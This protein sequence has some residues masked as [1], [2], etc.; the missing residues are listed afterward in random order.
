MSDKW[1]EILA[2]RLRQELEVLDDLY[3]K[4]V[5]LAYRLYFLDWV[6]RVPV[7]RTNYEEVQS[8]MREYDWRELTR[9]RED[10]YDDTGITINSV[11]QECLSAE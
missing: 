3:P 7:D 8:M 2:D 1:A 6:G 5:R 4:P 11:R 9:L 10:F